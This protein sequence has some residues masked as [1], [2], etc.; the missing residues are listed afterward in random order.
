MARLKNEVL[1]NYG[2]MN[3]ALKAAGQPE[4]KIEVKRKNVVVYNDQYVMWGTNISEEKGLMELMSIS[5]S[6][7][8][9]KDLHLH[10]EEF[11]HQFAEESVEEF[12]AKAKEKRAKL[13][14]KEKAQAERD[15]KEAEKKAKMEE[16]I[17]KMEEQE[18]QVDQAVGKEKKKEQAAS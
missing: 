5:L 18:K 11:L 9:K 12:E 4:L 13:E 14:A 1:F 15:A 6:R 2:K 17:K 7:G 8:S 10:W 16:R 3:E